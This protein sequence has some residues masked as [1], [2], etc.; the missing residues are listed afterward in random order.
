MLAAVCLLTA[1]LAV[2]QNPREAE[3]RLEKVRGELKSVAEERRQL[4]GK[5]GDAA[6][7]LR[8]ADEKVA[9]TGRSLAQ[10][11]QALQRHQQTLAELER[12]RDGLRS[13][14]TRQ[15][16]ELAQLLRAAYAIGGNAPL[17]LL[18]AQDRV[19]DANRLLAYHRYLQRER[20]QRIATLTHELQA[21]EQVQREVV[22]QKQQL[23]EAQRR[24][25]EQAQALQRD[26]KQRASVVSELDQRYQDRSEREKALGQDAKALE[27]LLA[28][29]RAAAARAEAE[30]RAAAKREAAEQAAQA[31]AAAKS[32]RGGGK[33]P[34]KVVASAPPLKV[35]G[36]G[37][38]LSGDLI[39][40]YGGRLPDGRTS[41]GVLIAAPAGSTVT[42]VA[43]GTV[44]FSDWM[45]GYGMI[46]IV[47]HGN[48]YMSLYAHNDTLLRDAGAK[49]KRG[50]AVAKVGNSGGQ[51]RPALYF[52]LRRNGQ[53]VDPSSWL[54]RR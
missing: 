15:R 10:T 31:K 32:G 38:P 9:A 24:Q 39:A 14:L 11:Q 22:E 37:W 13:G 46:L 30:R 4:E 34:P 7:Q 1:G 2:A 8:D 26:R 47:D 50:D 5:R 33:V 16:A 18:L 52:E 17:K 41:S 3:K 53:P 28:N 45:T 54:Q 49:V 36:L 19:A 35:G 44:V 29:L 12:K 27:T 21:L 48:G 25:Q 43:D 20:A 42:A 6:R 51:G 40:R 23:S